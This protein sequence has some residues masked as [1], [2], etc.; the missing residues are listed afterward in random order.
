MPFNGDML[1]LARQFRGLTQREFADAIKVDPAAVSRVENGL[2]KPTPDV[3]ERSASLLD[4]PHN[5]FVQLEPI[6][7]QPLS[8]HPMMWRKKAA[9]PQR[10]IDQAFAE[11]NIRIIQLR[12]LLRSVEYERILELPEFDLGMLKGGPEEA[13]SLVRKT[14][15]MP[16]GPV[17][18]LTSWVER[19]GCFV[20]HIELPDT[21]MAGVTIRPPGLPPCIFLQRDMPS[22]RMR[23][24]L[25]HELAHLV[26]HRLPTPNMEDEAN[27]FAGAFL[28]PAKDIRPYFIG[29]RVDLRLLAA[30]KPEWRVSMQALLMRAHQLGGLLTDTQV[31]YLWQQFNLRKI[32]LREPAELDFPTE[33]PSLLAKLIRLHI[34]DLGYSLDDMSKALLMH[35][36]ELSTFYAFE[37]EARRATLRL[38]S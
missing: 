5:F 24:T 27:R 14:W 13:A 31:R 22:D 17:R 21:A 29:K 19:A 37:A 25:A 18:D 11:I 34:S 33:T 23:L 7:G 16:A 3:E 4:L 1:R 20:M 35:E 38:V 9:T 15:L 8:V 6:Y 32:K 36:H 10:K 2:A 30:L 26:L 12:V 28:M